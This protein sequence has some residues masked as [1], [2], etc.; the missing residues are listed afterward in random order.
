MKGF[1]RICALALTVFLPHALQAQQATADAL[2]EKVLGKAD[3]PIT[4]IEYASLTCSHC[5]TFHN[6]TLPKVKSEW[7]DT[8]KAKLVFRDFPFD[9][10][11]LGAAMVAHCAGPEKY[12]GFLGTLFQTQAQWTKAS[13]PVAAL[14]NIAKLGG[15]G[16]QQFRDCLGNQAILGTI[17]QRQQEGQQQY[18][19]SSTPSFIINGRKVAGAMPYDE[20]AGL[21]KE[22]AK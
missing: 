13:D 6:E 10:L 1:L 22:A 3:A 7:I 8:G 15:M 2:P 18:G 9:G 5:A 11:G 17:R 4:I 21:L 12:F 16:E 19:I 20:F 14:Q